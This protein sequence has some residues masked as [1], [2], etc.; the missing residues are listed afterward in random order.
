[1]GQYKRDL[2][3]IIISLHFLILADELDFRLQ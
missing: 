2:T 1:M 3:I